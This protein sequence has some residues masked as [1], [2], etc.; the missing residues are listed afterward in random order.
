MARTR[1][2]LR[3][4]RAHQNS[5]DRDADQFKR[6]IAVV[7]ESLHQATLRLEKTVN[8]LAENHTLLSGIAADH[9]DKLHEREQRLKISNADMLKSLGEE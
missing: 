1:R 9:H 7:I 4:I 6:T 2:H 8:A 3:R 5:Q